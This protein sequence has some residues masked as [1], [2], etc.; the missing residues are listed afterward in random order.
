MIWAVSAPPATTQI[1]NPTPRT[2]LTPR[3]TAGSA[4]TASTSVG[5]PS[6][7]SPAT[8]DHR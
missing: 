6:S 1:A 5:A 7:V 8:S 4:L 3:I 2:A